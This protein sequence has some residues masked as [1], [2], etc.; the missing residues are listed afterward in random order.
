MKT[1]A[2]VTVIFL[3]AVA[4][5]HLARVLFQVSITVDKVVVPV[6]ASVVAFLAV[7][8]LAVWLWREQEVG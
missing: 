6:W 8:A 4:L 1:S 2:M 3:T 5:V 7:G